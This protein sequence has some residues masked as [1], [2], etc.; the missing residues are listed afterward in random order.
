MSVLSFLGILGREPSQ[1]NL[2]RDFLF[3]VILPNMQ[4]ASGV[5]ILGTEVSRLCQKVSF[6]NYSLADVSLLRYGPYTRSFTGF[7][8]IPDM[9]LEFVIPVRDFIEE[10]FLAWRLLMI[11]EKGFYLHKNSYSRDAHIRLYDRTGEIS[12][13]FKLEGVFPKTFPKFNISYA[14]E[15]VLRY[16]IEFNVDFIRKQP[17]ISDTDSKPVDIFSTRAFRKS[18]LS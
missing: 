15:D 3:E 13:E 11:D 5:S 18:I 1:A 8:E 17:L 14:S 4:S 12:S 9:V 2:Q 6:G 16:P 7:F 10:Y